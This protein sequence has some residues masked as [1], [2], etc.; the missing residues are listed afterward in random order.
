MLADNLRFGEQLKL[1]GCN[2]R[3]RIKKYAEIC[4]FCTHKNVAA[5]FEAFQALAQGSQKRINH[6]VQLGGF[7]RA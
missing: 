4:C 1:C 2:S 3:H 6:I 5:I 7:R